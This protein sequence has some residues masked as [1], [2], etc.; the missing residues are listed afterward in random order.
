[1]AT[2]VPHRAV[3]IPVEYP[4]YN[5]G[6]KNLHNSPFQN[7]KVSIPAIFA[8]QRSKKL[9]AKRT[10]SIMN[11]HP[12]IVAGGNGRRNGGTNAVPA[13]VCFPSHTQTPSASAEGVCGLSL[14]S[15]VVSL[16]NA[17]RTVIG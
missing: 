17:A 11:R 5:G 3:D 16:Y 6:G 10:L 2:I 1:M 4:V 9:T 12:L 14:L 7:K 15:F 13:L 8:L